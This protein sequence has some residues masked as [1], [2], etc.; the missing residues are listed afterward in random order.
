MPRCALQRECNVPAIRIFTNTALY[1][2]EKCLAP[3]LSENFSTQP[4]QKHASS[5]IRMG[6]EE[7]QH[8][9]MIDFY[10]RQRPE[11]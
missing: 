5:V 8:Y 10:D 9:G 1:R 3:V 4:R 11:L 2:C 7:M 6:C